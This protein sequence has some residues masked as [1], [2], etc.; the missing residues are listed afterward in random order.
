MDVDTKYLPQTNKNTQKATGLER[1]KMSERRYT[2]YYLP[3]DARGE[4]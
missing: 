2:M 1:D 3:S 4:K